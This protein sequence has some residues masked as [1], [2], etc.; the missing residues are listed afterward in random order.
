MWEKIQLVVWRVV[1]F[2]EASWNPSISSLA[3]LEYRGIGVSTV[4]VSG[5]N[6][7]AITVT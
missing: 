4:T 6:S 7:G 3:L 5:E 1:S 2:R